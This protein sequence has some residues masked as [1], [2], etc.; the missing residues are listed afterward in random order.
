MARSLYEEPHEYP[1]DNGQPNQEVHPERLRTD[2]GGTTPAHPDWQPD[3][4]DKS[5]DPKSK[6]KLIAV[7]A[8]T[9]VGAVAIAGAAL[10]SAKN[11]VHELGNKLA[12]ADAA[13][14]AP[15]LPGQG[16]PEHKTTI[17]IDA[18]TPDQFYSDANF[19]DEQRVDWAWNKINQPSHEAGYEGMTL[20]QAAHKQ[21]V[22]R[23]Q[24]EKEIELEKGMGMNLFPEPVEPSENL[25]G[26]QI[27][28]IESSVE[29]IAAASDLSDIDRAKV[30]A[31][32]MD[33][34]NPNLEKTMSLAM[35]RS[36][37]N[38]GG[39]GQ[40]L[41]D[42]TTKTRAE[43]PVF[44][45]YKPENGYDPNGVPSKI[46]TALNVTAGGSKP[47]YSQA[48]VRFINHKPVFVDAYSTDNKSK[49]IN[50]PEQIPQD[51]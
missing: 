47:S 5:H 38:M 6:N 12:G 48:I 50:A 40:V 43:S 34:A 18:A 17:D 29:Q 22:K 24:L 37:Q 26:D 36:A 45:H 16:S 51:S 11:E 8:A 42:T 23:L 10:F 7:I 3:P 19:T 2:F 13:N 46:I 39:V 4:L 25:D 31:A 41:V 44:R 1:S 49:F 21:L 35:N 20:L 30:L 33:N 9:G 28:A 32:V 15:E 14:S 27:L